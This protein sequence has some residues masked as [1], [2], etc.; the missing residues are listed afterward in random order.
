MRRPLV[1]GDKDERIYL[2]NSGPSNAKTVEMQ[3]GPYEGF[4]DAENIAKLKAYFALTTPQL[5][6]K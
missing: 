2:S 4:L 6:P 5:Q 1:F 3:L